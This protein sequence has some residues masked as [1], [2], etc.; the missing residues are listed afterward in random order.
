MQSEEMEEK[1][2]EVS[3]G[4]GTCFRTTLLLSFGRGGAR[5]LFQSKGRCP[6]G[7][8]ATLVTAWNL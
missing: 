2:K 7:H 4:P 1:G 6:L 8:R 3:L 5:I